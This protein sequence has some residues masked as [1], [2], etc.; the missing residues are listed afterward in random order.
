MECGP[1][2]GAAGE[3]IFP[4]ID[5]FALLIF[6]RTGPHGVG[7]SLFPV[8]RFRFAN[9]VLPAETGLLD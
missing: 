7:L 1:V 4:E 8:L 3:M 6:G 9:V 5:L 2:F